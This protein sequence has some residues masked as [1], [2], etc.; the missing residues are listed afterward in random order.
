[1]WV[2]T[3]IYISSYTIQ[4][5]TSH[6]CSPNVL[7]SS[8]VT[9]LWSIS[10][11]LAAGT[12][13]EGAKSLPSADVSLIWYTALCT[14][15]KLIGHTWF[16]HQSVN[17]LSVGTISYSTLKSREILEEYLVFVCR[18]QQVRKERKKGKRESKTQ[19]STGSAAPPASDT[20]P[21]A[22]PSRSLFHL[23]SCTWVPISASTQALL[24]IANSYSANSYGWM[25]EL[26]VTPKWHELSLTTTTQPVVAFESQHSPRQG[27]NM[28]DTGLSPDHP[29]FSLMPT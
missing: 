22:L 28:E 19:M 26:A 8:S 24:W 21:S 23:V 15:S 10:D 2:R 18:L 20:R 6:Y 12:N 14:H 17:S 5:I 11:Q 13:L 1:M 16:L 29:P 4:P 3:S 9:L 25:W 27:Q 7:I